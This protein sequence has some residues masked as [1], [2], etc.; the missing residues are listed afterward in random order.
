[1]CWKAPSVTVSAFTFKRERIFRGG[2][3]VLES[4]HLE[5]EFED[6]FYIFSMEIEI[7]IVVLTCPTKLAEILIPIICRWRG[8]EM[9][10]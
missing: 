1:M 3:I 2:Q 8:V 4:K 6:T 5:L 9:E 10:V 7:G